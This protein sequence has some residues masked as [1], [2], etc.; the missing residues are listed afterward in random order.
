MKIVC[1][2]ECMVEVSAIPG[3]PGLANVGFG[4]DTLNTAVYLSRLL[5]GTDHQVAYATLLGD[6]PYGAHMLAEW[7]TEGIDCSFAEIAD[8]RETGLYAIHVDE[9]GERRFYYWRDRA[10]VRELFDGD[11]GAR[12]A[13]TLLDGDAI[14]FSGITLAV[15]NA[16]GRERLIDVARCMKDAGKH[17]AFDTNYRRRLWRSSEPD[18]I[19][20]QAFSV[21]TIL[22]PSIA[23]LS[24]V[25]GDCSGGWRDF[26]EN[27]GVP[28]IV[29]TAGS[30]E[31]E[32]LLEGTW[33]DFQGET[34][35][36]VDTTAAGDSFN[37]GYLAARLLGQDQRTSVRAGHR[38]AS[39][40]IRFAGA[41]IPA[42]RMPA[43]RLESSIP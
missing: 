17:V 2:G 41:I 22:L 13:H 3:E 15:L 14:Y 10:P 39:R 36:P 20:L 43:G 7:K 25:F 21:A 33:L 1:I 37:A 23:D 28:E 27:L 34:I 38:L 11:E 8:G 18:E 4:G 30:G 32:M 19:Y 12:R 26:L 16:E 24:A 31:I 6:D 5:A 9:Y 42:S 35:T 29:V 40:V